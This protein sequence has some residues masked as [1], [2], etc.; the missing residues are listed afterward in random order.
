VTRSSLRD[1]VGHLTASDPVLHAIS[2]LS[3]IPRQQ[4][5]TVVEHPEDY[6]AAGGA[7]DTMQIRPESPSSPS[8]SPNTLSNVYPRPPIPIR[9][10]TH[11]IRYSASYWDRFPLEPAWRPTRHRLLTSQLKFLTRQHFTPPHT[12]VFLQEVLHNQFVDIA[13]HSLP[14]DQWVALGVGRDDGEQKGE[15]EAVF[16]RKDACRLVHWETRWLNE[17]GEVGKKGWDAGSVRTVTCVVLDLLEPGR[18]TEAVGRLLLM[19]AHLDNEGATSRY[20]SAKL[21]LKITQELREK[22]R[23]DYWVVGGDFNS[24]KKDAAYETMVN[25]TG[26]VDARDV[27]SGWTYDAESDD[28][29]QRTDGDPT[30]IEHNDGIVE[31]ASEWGDDRWGEFMTYTGFDGIGEKQP[32]EVQRIDFLFVP[33]PHHLQLQDGRGV[34][35]YA[36]IPNSFEGSKDGRVSDHRAVVVDLLA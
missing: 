15:H 3:A 33:D 30:P 14:P 13:T 12:F 5:S 23:P 35:G 22:Y 25:E 34:K 17:T 26:L 32:K 11:N 19:N 16:Y 4:T 21:L 8:F 29:R 9:V 10:I 6:A 2:W 20:E 7:L 1:G 36:V 28:A 31:I 18:G 27:L 24:P